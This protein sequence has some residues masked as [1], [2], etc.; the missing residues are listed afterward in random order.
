MALERHLTLVNGPM[1][2]QAGT[3]LG[4]EASN[5][6]LLQLI[7]ENRDLEVSSNGHDS[8]HELVFFGQC[9][10]GRIP[11]PDGQTIAARQF[12]APVEL[13][14]SQ[15]G[16]RRDN[17]TSDEIRLSRNRAVLAVFWQRCLKSFANGRQHLAV[18]HN[19]DD[20]SRTVYN[21]I[22]SMTPLLLSR[23]T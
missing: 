6:L 11:S 12:S 14:S 4:L 21:H 13:F 9:Y 18:S 15:S 10:I 20:R 23:G 7:T 8:L 22:L 2:L 19:T 5:K 17:D 16:S 3:H 1:G